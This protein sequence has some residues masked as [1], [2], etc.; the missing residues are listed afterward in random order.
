VRRIATNGVVATVAGIGTA[1]ST[2]DG[3]PA[4][5]AKLNR[6]KGIGLDGTG[7]LFIA[8]TNGHRVRRVD[9]A[10]GRIKTVVGT[11]AGFAGDGGPA[12]AAKLR[13]P[14]DVFV[15]GAGDLLVV[16]EGNHRIR[17]VAA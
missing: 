10:S 3:G 7:N 13:V 17:R 6:P 15:D 11:G 5:A 14:R 12:T 16:D 4:A 2:G 1:G 8:D 9:V